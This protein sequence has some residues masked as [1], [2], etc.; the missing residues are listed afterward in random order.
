MQVFDADGRYVRTEGVS[1]AVAGTVEKE[2]P[3]PYKDLT[4]EQRYVAEL[5]DKGRAR[6]SAR[7]E[8]GGATRGWVEWIDQSGESVEY[9]E[10]AAIEE[11]G[12]TATWAPYGVRLAA[13]G[14]VIVATPWPHDAPIREREQRLYNLSPSGGAGFA[15][16]AS[17][18]DAAAPGGV[19]GY[20]PGRRG[21]VF[22]RNPAQT[23]SGFTPPTTT[24]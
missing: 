19:I 12:Y 24:L 17:E 11:L 10:V 23:I 13:G 8:V 3:D 18:A 1:G 22:P 9:L 14:H 6:L 7:A 2:K 16:G 20:A 21:D 4:P 5:A 15:S